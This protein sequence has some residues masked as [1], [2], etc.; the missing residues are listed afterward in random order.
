MYLSAVNCVCWYLCVSRIIVVVYDG[1]PKKNFTSIRREK[2][3]LVFA[4]LP[5]F[6][7]SPVALPPLPH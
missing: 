3:R 6:F 2:R 4:S 5:S 7:F 1:K